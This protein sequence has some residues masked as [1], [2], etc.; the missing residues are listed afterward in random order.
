MTDPAAPADRT[1]LSHT[2]ARARTHTPDSRCPTVQG[3]T[4]VIDLLLKHGA[5]VNRAKA[6][7]AT[8]LFAAAQQ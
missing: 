3:H 5:D 1:P 6:D 2:H 4:D 8:P 7:G